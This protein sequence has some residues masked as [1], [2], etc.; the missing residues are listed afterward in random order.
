MPYGRKTYKKFSKTQL[1]RNT[2]K[3]NQ[4]SRMVELKMHRSTTTNTGIGTASLLIPLD[5]I[6]QGDSSSTREG[7]RISPDK[8]HIRVALE[9]ENADSYNLM[10]CMLIQSKVG[11]LTSANFP[12]V[13]QPVAPADLSRYTILYDKVYS[14]NSK[15]LG[16]VAS[17]VISNFEI[18]RS[19]PNKIYYP[20]AG[21]A[22]Y[23]G[24]LYIYFVS[25]SAA[26]P[27]PDVEHMDC[28]FYYKDL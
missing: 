1:A 17:D 9:S 28:G 24:N 16:G 6:S 21:T 3:V 10:R 2:R 5:A 26:V 13:M 27:Y 18:K 8:V 23:K 12:S 19:V 20:D 11:V 14:L 15:D 25:D 7:L 22:A 4:L